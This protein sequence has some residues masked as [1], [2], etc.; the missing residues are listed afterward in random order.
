MSKFLVYATAVLLMPL[1][2]LAAP[3]AYLPQADSPCITVRDLAVPDDVSSCHISATAPVTQLEALPSGLGLYVAVQGSNTLHRYIST[4]AG[5]PAI[6]SDTSLPAITLGGAALALAASPDSQTLWVAVSGSKNL[7]R[8]DLRDHSTSTLP[9]N[10]NPGQ[11]VLDK[12]GSVLFVAEKDGTQ[13]IALDLRAEEVQVPASAYRL[14]APATS[15]ALSGDGS[16][17][18]ASHASPASVSVIWGNLSSKIGTLEV[19]GVRSV[20]AAGTHLYAVTAGQVRVW[21]SSTLEEL[22]ALT[23]SGTPLAVALNGEGDQ[24]LAA[25][26]NGQLQQLS[27][28]DSFGSPYPPSGRFVAPYRPLVQLMRSQYGAAEN[29]GTDT[30]VRL[31]RLGDAYITGSV[32]VQTF[33]IGVSNDFAKAGADYEAFDSDLQFDVGVT[34]ITIPITLINDSYYGLTEN[35]GLRLTFPEDSPFTAGSIL[36]ATFGI[37][38]DDSDPRDRGGCT[39]GRGRGDPLLPSLLAG[40]VLMLWRRQRQRRG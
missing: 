25:S 31:I 20:Y 8:I 13:L 7:L 39:L 27:L 40:S 24:L 12:T 33:N 32:H 9:L 19:P 38:N 28:P 22:D 14:D 5:R 15:L 21:L 6:D 29:A 11:L 2:S 26:S 37:S 35:F 30:S 34:S 4:A 1:A 17:L 10:F 16:R 18:F 23:V 3:Y 36:E